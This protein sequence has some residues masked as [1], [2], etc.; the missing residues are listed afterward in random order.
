MVSRKFGIAGLLVLALGGFY[1][2]LDTWLPGSVPLELPADAGES[3]AGDAGDAAT[4][5]VA[6]ALDAAV[7]MDAAGLPDR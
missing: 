7:E 1:L 2:A 5:S 6:V 3:D 4:A